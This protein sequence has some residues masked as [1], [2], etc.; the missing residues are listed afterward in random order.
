M[1][2]TKK[3]AGASCL[4][5]RV[6]QVRDRPAPSIIELQLAKTEL[7]M[8]ERRFKARVEEGRPGAPL[9]PQFDIALA[10]SQQ[11]QT[12]RHPSTSGI[13]SWLSVPNRQS[14]PIVAPLDAALGGITLQGLQSL[15]QRLSTSPAATPSPAQAMLAQPS[16][17]SSTQQTPFLHSPLPGPAVSSGNG[18]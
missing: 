3:Y 15:I 18:L 1:R 13:P 9:V 10:L 16:L 7:D 2:V 12:S 14:P 17:T 11:H 8:L 6:F 5:R 4:G